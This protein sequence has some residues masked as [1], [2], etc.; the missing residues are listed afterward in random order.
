MG[1]A[2]ISH[3]VIQSKIESMKNMYSS[4][5]KKPDSY[6]FSALTIKSVFYK[7]PSLDF[8]ENDIEECVVDGQYDGGVDVLLSDPSSETSDLVIGQAKYYSTIT[9]DDMKDAILKMALFFKD[10]EKGRYEQVN[11][12]VQQR[13]LTLYSDVGEESKI[14]FILFTSAPRNR[15]RDDSLKKCFNEQF[16][17]DDR[18]ELVVL[19][20]KDI[21]EEIK[22]AESRRPNVESG[23]I[24]IDKANNYLEYQDES[25]VVVNVSAFS[26]KQLY[27]Q[28]SISLL[29]RNLR[30]HVKGDVDKEINTTINT[31]P[32]LFW[33]KNNG[34]TIICDDFLISG[35]EVKLTNFSIVNGGQTTHM[36]HKSNKINEDSDLY[37]VCKIIKTVGDT[38]DDKN[39]YSLEIAK[40]T[41]TQKPIKPVDLKANAPE[42]IRFAQNMRDVGVF[43]TTKRGEKIPSAYSQPYSHTDL[44]SVGKLCLA[45]LFQAPCMSRN[46][47][48]QIYQSK[49]YDGIFGGN[50][51][52]VAKMCRELL[53]IDY[54]FRNAFIKRFDSE[55][56]NHPNKAILLQ[57]SHNARTLC[58]AF[59][60]LASMYYQ[61]KVQNEGLQVIFAASRNESKDT[62]DSVLSS[63]GQDKVVDWILPKN[64][65]ADKDKYDEVLYQLFCSIIEV[66]VTSY[67]IA[68]NYESDLNATNFLKKDKN[69][70]GILKANWNNLERMILSVFGSI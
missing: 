10:M 34:I 44:P 6:V 51:I 65:F 11:E 66:G 25:A 26:I 17:G 39:Q 47:P 20:G 45:A 62:M 64:L 24:T 68:A 38:E 57:F 18:Y 63:F 55:N 1:N 61:K 2:D 36:L 13:F 9:A 52:S 5:R 42:Q 67:E 12:K 15:I 16:H 21:E 41:N 35:R 70:Y 3:E 49:I 32:E 19:F 58:I 28:Y 59:V 53:Y 60:S 46:K 22:E 33:M 27:A 54:Y 69:Y 14:R 40:A 4:L 8:T 48:S 23:K 56:E 7:N 30:Y 43:Y 37:L 50:Q 31:E 29:A